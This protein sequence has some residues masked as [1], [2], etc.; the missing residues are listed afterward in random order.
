MK[1]RHTESN[2]SASLDSI[3]Q[4]MVP[5]INP[6]FSQE[7]STDDRHAERAA[8]QYEQQQVDMHNSKK[9]PNQIICVSR[10]P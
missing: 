9:Y 8:K 3:E 7:K 4:T 6:F 10:E 1:W 2:R 5:I